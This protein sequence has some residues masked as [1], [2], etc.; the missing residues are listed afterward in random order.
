MRDFTSSNPY[1]TVVHL[2][3][4]E[5]E[6][7]YQKKYAVTA[8]PK[9]YFISPKGIIEGRRLDLDSLSQLI[10]IYESYSDYAKAK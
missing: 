5:M 6:S 8:T 7:D 3:D 4:P 10:A 9:L 1:V 2:S